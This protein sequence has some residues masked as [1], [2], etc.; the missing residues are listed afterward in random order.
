MNKSAQSRFHGIL[1]VYPWEV[2]VAR[3]TPVNR[4]LLRF[5]LGYVTIVLV[6][7]VGY[8]PVYLEIIK[9]VRENAINDSYTVFRS[10]FAL[11]DNQLAQIREVAA[12]LRRDSE[13]ER[14]AAI[15]GDHV[16]TTQ[17]LSMLKAKNLMQAIS[18]SEL[19]QGVYFSFASNGILIGTELVSAQRESVYGNY[20]QEE[21]LSAS[22]WFDQVF[23]A[24][25]PV[26]YQFKP[27]RRYLIGNGVSTNLQPKNT[28]LFL[29]YPLNSIGRY[30]DTALI[31]LLDASYI[32]RVLRSEY[33]AGKLQFVL[34]NT[35]REAILTDPPNF[36]VTSWPES[37]VFHESDRGADTTVFSIQSSASGLRATARIPTEAF[38]DRIERFMGMIRLFFGLSVLFSLVVALI[39]A[40]RNSLPL[41]LI[42]KSLNLSSQKTVPGRDEYDAIQGAISDMSRTQL[43]YEGVIRNLDAA[44]RMTTFEK[45]LSGTKG[46]PEELSDA[47]RYFPFL[48]EPYRILILQWEEG[49]QNTLIK[50][51]A[52]EEVRLTLPAALYLHSLRSRHLIAVLPEPENLDVGDSTF[53][54]QISACLMAVQVKIGLPVRAGVSLRG[55][56]QDDVA[57]CWNQAMDVLR[58]PDA[59]AEGRVSVYRAEMAFAIQSS[60]DMQDLQRLYEVLLAG[61]AAAVRK[62]LESLYQV[63]SGKSVVSSTEAR[64]VYVSIQNI[65]ELVRK[66]VVKPGDMPPV[67]QEYSVEK[68]LVQLFEQLESSAQALAELVNSRKKS[69][70]THLRDAILDYLTGHFTEPNLNG[71]QVAEALGISEKYLFQFLRE[72]TG[73]T[74]HDILQNL[75]FEK[76]KT[77][78]RGTKLPIGEIALQT[79]FNSLNTFTKTFRKTFGVPPGAWRAGQEGDS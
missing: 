61:N 26:N 37:G 54:A 12:I 74:Y 67:Y 63:V 70:N 47:G 15:Q 71:V 8:L 36:A 43:E 77:L 23:P 14:L 5:L 3:F 18:H 6:V 9:A 21:G 72:Q 59:A 38:T 41:N 22:Q 49:H 45:L 19:F 44:V 62:A 20:F 33:L 65:L 52:E 31:C 78:M 35:Q 2:A 58:S 29:S 76:A 16:P 17:Y 27:M 28:V 32:S 4:S 30:S 1:T 64:N 51:L 68:S 48:A 60:L 69:R 50:V 57:R 53:S 75:R 34:E 25:G 73:T 66:K 40:Y 55:Q 24:P 46:E 7:S 11:V 39:F 10:G 56:G 42:L 13:I 79:G